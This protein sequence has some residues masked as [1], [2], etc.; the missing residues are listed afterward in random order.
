ML[1]K[2][3]DALS[4]GEFVWLWPK[5]TLLTLTG[6]FG[7]LF[8]R[9]LGFSFRDT[10]IKIWIAYIALVI[11]STVFAEDNLAYKILGGGGRLDGL[12][13]QLA[14]A[15][16][17]IF[18][19]LVF[20]KLPK[21]QER[22]LKVLTI[23]GVIE[24]AILVSQRLG[25]D[26]VGQLVMHGNY[27][28]LVGTIGNPGMIASL[29][30]L[31]YFSAAT[32]R[33]KL[34]QLLSLLAIGIGIGITSSKSVIFASTGVLIGL[35]LWTR[36][37]RF[38]FLAILLIVST[39]LGKEAL[40]NQLGYSR[41]LTNMHSLHARE[42]IWKLAVKSITLT[43]G[44]PVIGAGPDG[45]FNLV[46]K[47]IPIQ[48]VL[49]LYRVEYSWPPDA[50]IKEVKILYKPEDPPRSRAFLVI[51]DNYETE[52]G[53]KALIYKYYLDKAHNLWLDRAI[54]YGIVASILWLA[55]F[56]YPLFKFFFTKNGARK[57][58]DMLLISGGLIALA[59]YYLVWFPVPQ[60]EPIHVA[61]LALIWTQV[62]G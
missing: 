34:L 57:T 27:G 54:D 58:Y 43:P 48:D 20:Q 45:F 35:F 60:V 55:I 13:Y 1:F 47:K 31:A 11:L 53:K 56:A 19:Y 49:E 2:D 33:Q 61:Y 30:L 16:W 25:Y 38:L 14:L 52:H 7:I 9:D 21:T 24:T 23:I 22:F 28:K 40:P 51:F 18:A 59:L 41:P 15:S 26:P 62:K 4:T 44:Q 42:I 5:L 32:L 10:Y 36:K 17:A 3:L 46:V 50:R 12:L 37:R 29:L 39:Y 6:V 8:W